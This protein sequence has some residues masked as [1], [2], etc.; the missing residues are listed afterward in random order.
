M[1]NMQVPAEFAH[2]LFYREGDEMEIKE[3]ISIGDAS[4]YPFIFDI[5]YN[6]QIP[7]P[8]KPWSERD[9][10]L[11]EIAYMWRVKQ[12]A[13]SFVHKERNKKKVMVELPNVIALYI[14]FLFWING[15]PVSN[16]KYLHSEIE[17]L[18]WKPVNVTE[19]LSF[20]LTK[21]YL[22]HSFV[23][24]NELFMETEKLFVKVKIKEKL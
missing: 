12:A 21:P 10:T 13:I 9:K 3:E 8:I 11:K 16:L 23:Q 2:P 7:L 22:Y 1:K 18:V 4:A 14:S 24:L 6:K 15:K 5:Y 20:I 17:K 19:R